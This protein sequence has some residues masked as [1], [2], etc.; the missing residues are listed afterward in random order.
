M[1]ETA[2]YLAHSKLFLASERS[3]YLVFAGLS[4]G[5]I[6]LT[7][8]LYFSDRF[9]FERFIG[10][11]NPL[12][13]SVL[14]VLSGL[15]LLSFLLFRGWFTIYEKASL[16]GLIRRSGLAAGFGLIV[17]LVDSSVRLYPADLNILFPA[18]L[19]FYPAIALYAEILFQVLPLSV[20]LFILTS[21]FK[22]NNSNP[23]IWAGIFAVSLLEPIYQVM[24]L[25][26]GNYPLWFVAFVFLHVFLVVL[27]QLIIFKRNDFVSMYS[28]RLAY[29][30]LWHIV[31]GYLRLH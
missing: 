27:T 8:I 7:G 17:I 20:V 30:T 23:I 12:I 21:I 1:K 19:L 31:W 2:F 22:N 24:P 26:S 6:G 29:Y 16:E 4:M 15:V 11:I 10:G 5:A 28:F 25:V 14:M 3:Q 9:L 18:S 13:A